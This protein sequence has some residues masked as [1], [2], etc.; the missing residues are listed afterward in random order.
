MEENQGHRMARAV[1]AKELA[2]NPLLTQV[3]EQ[4]KSDIFQQWQSAGTVEDRE[5]AWQALRQLE[6]LAGAIHDAIKRAISEQPGGSPG[7]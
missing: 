5:N 2:R 6:L 3:L 7:R 1:Q 4:R